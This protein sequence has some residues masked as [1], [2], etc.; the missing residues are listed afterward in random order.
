MAD[1]EVVFS[2][3]FVILFFVIPVAWVIL[4]L[5]KRRVRQA[6]I[7]LT[8]E[9]LKTFKDLYRQPHQRGGMPSRFAEIADA[10]DRAR[11]AAVSTSLVVLLA[12]CFV[13]FTGRGS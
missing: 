2:F 13:I 5:A 6:E 10:T 11:R 4:E 9:E 7:D 1:P 3:P 8:A 12:F